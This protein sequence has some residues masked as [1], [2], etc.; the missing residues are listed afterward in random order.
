MGLFSTFIVTI[1]YRYQQ[2]QHAYFRELEEL[3]I[4]HENAI[5]HTQL[6][7]QEYTFQTISRE[8]HDNIGQKLTLAKLH[9][10]TLPPDDP[11][12]IIAR[13]SDSVLMISQ[14]INDLSDISRSMSTEFILNNGLI[15]GI[16]LTVEQ[17][18]RSES[19]TIE[20]IL[21]GN[22]IFLP[23]KQ[24][25]VLFRI[26]QEG[27]NNVIKH[28]EAKKIEI[29]LHF[30]NEILSLQIKDDG[31]GFNPDISTRKNGLLNI[32]KRASLLNGTLEIISNPK[33]SSLL[34]QIPININEISLSE[35]SITT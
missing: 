26:V 32:Q 17:L 14:A 23:N 7:M 35:L 22:T 21:T 11:E 4:V 34:I 15:K 16:E 12:K 33:G 6:E 20:F 10:N 9:L 24:E 3:R 27:I 13:I 25:L 31:I 18:I 30:D 28:A 2:K 5:L 19:Y 1:I 8:I 29:L